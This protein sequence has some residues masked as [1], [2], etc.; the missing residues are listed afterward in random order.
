M[1]GAVPSRTLLSA[2]VSYRIRDTGATLWVQGRNLTGKQYV[3]DYQNG[4]RPGAPRTVV[5]GLSIV[6]D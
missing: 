5:A 6:F 1:L 2:R 4:M 3:S